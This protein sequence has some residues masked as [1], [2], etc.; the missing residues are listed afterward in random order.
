M[1]DIMSD[2][3]FGQRIDTMSTH[4]PRLILDALKDYGWRMG[5]YM[6]APS[7]DKLQIERIFDYLGKN[8][9]SRKWSQFYE[10]YSSAVLDD[11]KRK[12]KGRFFLFQ[13]SVDPI[14]RAPLS[15]SALSAEGFFLMLAGLAPRKIHKH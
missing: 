15:R 11:P 10:K 9:E 3:A 13:D 6:Q 1:V 5:I 2:F 12:E 14:T 8:S 7:L 4:H